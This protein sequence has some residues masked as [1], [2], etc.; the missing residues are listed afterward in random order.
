MARVYPELPIIK[1]NRLKPEPGELFLLEYL[2]ENLDDSYEVFF[3]PFLNGDRPDIIL[4]RQGFG[5]MIIEVKDW[6]LNNYYLDDKRKWKLRLN[7]A[8]IKSPIDQVLHYKNN[9]YNLHIDSLL[10]RKIKN[11]KYWSLVTC[12]VYFH[13]ATSYEIE[14]LLVKPYQEDK[15]YIKFLK[16]NIDLLGCDNLNLNYLS[17]LFQKRYIISTSPSK[18]FDLSLYESFKRYFKPTFHSREEGV[19]I[20]FTDQQR[21]LVNSL[22]KAEQRVKG[23]VGAGKTTV[24]AA[25][26]VNAH[27][28]HGERVLLLCYNVTLRNYIHDK[29]SRVREDFLWSN[30]YINNYHNFLSAEMNNNGIEFKLP[31]NF[32]EL[33]QDEKSNFFETK[34]FSNVDLFENCKDNLEKYKTILVDEIQDYHRPWMDLIKENFL[35]E[36]GEY[37]IWGDEK[38][39]IYGNELEEKDLRTNVKGR[40]SEL[41]DSFRS[42]KKIKDLAVQFQKKNFSDKYVIDNFDELPQL[43][44]DYDNPSTIN[45]L[46][47]ENEKELSI[48]KLF[49]LISEYSIR[50]EEH[51]NDITVLGFRISVLREFECYYRYKTNE[52][53]NAM[54]ETQEVWY[55]L[56]LQTFKDL[57]TINKGLNLFKYGSIEDKKNKLAVL[58]AVRDLVSETDENLFKERLTHLLSQYQVKQIHFE[59][60]YNSNDLVNLL[61]RNKHLSLRKLEA[62]YPK[63]R[64]LTNS[65]KTIRDN[66]KHHFWYDRGTIKLSTI[67]SFKGWEANTLFL[68]L[69][70]QFDNSDFMTSFEELIY[71]AITRSKTNL[72]VLNYGNTVHHQRMVDLFDKYNKGFS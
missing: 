17:S 33:T 23:V 11:F 28:R 35:A 10:E 45:Y 21:R 72:I 42:V 26:A 46:Y 4:M 55:K 61:N 14:N 52:R 38:Q 40:P 16:W 15:D 57:E 5:V 27:R 22:P 58:L 1:S 63:Y 70:E 34:Y 12:A 18:L 6:K 2:Y 47:F 8:H 71:T 13:N 19:E 64:K 3:Q 30:F 31:P 41:K 68:I 9:L 54:F 20:K 32:T 44:L 48:V 60:W 59:S 7:N 25:R 37:V 65:L 29:I 43:L 56:F 69:E 53:T 50:L 36:D 67:H 49:D 51:P 39:N 24:M 62:K 66:K